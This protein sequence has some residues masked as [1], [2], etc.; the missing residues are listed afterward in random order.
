MHDV[1]RS[2]I[3]T[4]QVEEKEE[5]SISNNNQ[6]VSTELD[7]QQISKKW[8]QSLQRL[9]KLLSKACFYFF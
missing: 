2:H 5:A 8:L 6:Q 4:V 1:L 7:S 9:S 3:S